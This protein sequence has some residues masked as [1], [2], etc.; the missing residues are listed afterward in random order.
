M[1]ADRPL[2]SVIV[3]AYNYG[4]VIPA[5]IASVQ[6]QTLSDCEIVLVDDESTDD[7]SAIVAAIAARD[8][9]VRLHRQKNGGLASARNAGLRIAR[10]KYVQFLDADDLLERSKLATHAKHL[11]QH[12]DVGIVYGDV[13]YFPTE[14]PT[15]QRRSLYE[16]DREW[17]PMVSGSGD[18]VLAKLIEANIMV[19]SSPLVRRTLIDTVGLFD[20]TLTV[21][22]DWDYWIRSALTGAKFVYVDEPDTRTLVRVHSTSLSQNRLRMIRVSVDVRRKLDVRLGEGELK[23]RNR[24]LEANELAHVGAQALMRG[25][26]EG[27]E[28]IAA[29][30]RAAPDL[31]MRMNY[32]AV[33][34]MAAWFPKAFEGE[35]PMNVKEAVKRVA[36]VRFGWRG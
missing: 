29:A 19:V 36:R 21:L 13:R 10:G 9:R 15:R 32:L 8:P 26:S 23:R 22:E 30:A 24:Q 17:M 4:R 33:S 27:A 31:Q 34:R 18:T 6:E 1:S 7:T 3:P 14:D 11:E 20:T 2:V 28:Q 12:P 16:P 25:E 5:T 35:A